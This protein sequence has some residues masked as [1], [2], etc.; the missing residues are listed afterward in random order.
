MIYR[1]TC[2]QTQSDF[3]FVIPTKLARLLDFCHTLD[4]H[5]AMALNNRATRGF[6]ALHTG[7]VHSIEKKNMLQNL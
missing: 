2:H 5:L 3:Q 4:P 6:I 1:G 7:R